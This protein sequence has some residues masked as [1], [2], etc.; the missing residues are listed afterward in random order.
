M[1]TPKIS[2]SKLN[3][4][5][6]MSERL[7]NMSGEVLCSQKQISGYAPV[8]FVQLEPTTRKSSNVP[9]RLLD[10]ADVHRSID[11]FIDY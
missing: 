11:L 8:T 1:G 9:R 5:E 2:P 6:M 7:L 10:Q 3:W 4:I